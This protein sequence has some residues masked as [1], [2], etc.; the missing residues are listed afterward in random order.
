MVIIQ[1]EHNENILI[2]CVL[3]FVRLPEG[4]SY[5]LDEVQC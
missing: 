3:G 4:V 5:G 2:S 1:C